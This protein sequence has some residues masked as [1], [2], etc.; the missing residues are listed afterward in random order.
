MGFYM[1][2]VEK[3]QTNVV[4]NKLQHVGYNRKT[5]AAKNKT[6]YKDQLESIVE[7]V[8]FLINTVGQRGKTRI[9]KGRYSMENRKK[10][11]CL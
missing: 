4:F 5:Q 9:T 8:S 2:I 11:L 6:K 10:T 3:D 7:S 1:G